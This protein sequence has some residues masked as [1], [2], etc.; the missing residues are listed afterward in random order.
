MNVHESE[1]MTNALVQH[2]GRVSLF[3][4]VVE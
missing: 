2:D 1:M 3:R 4:A